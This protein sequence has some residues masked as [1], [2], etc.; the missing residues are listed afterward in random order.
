MKFRFY[1]FLV[2]FFSFFSCENPDDKCSFYDHPV[3]NYTR[4]DI[5]RKI[6]SD[7]DDDWRLN[8][9]FYNAE[10]VKVEPAF[11]NP[12]GGNPIINVP[13]TVKKNPNGLLSN[14]G[15][16]AQDSSGNWINIQTGIIG[17]N[18]TPDPGFYELK[19]DLR[20]ID[21]G[22]STGKLSKITGLH[23]IYVIDDS[24]IKTSLCDQIISYGD[25][26][27]TP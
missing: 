2:A 12:N 13:V 11:P 14:V 5:N 6:I 10:Y 26:N 25:I 24:Y 23:R 20:K 7:D 1:I 22:T 19:I 15:I 4:T 3:A 17:I 16:I 9:N 18:S 8:V 27:I 21:N